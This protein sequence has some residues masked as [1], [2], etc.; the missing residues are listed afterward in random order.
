[1]EIIYYIPKIDCEK[2]IENN[3][4]TELKNKANNQTVFTD[5]TSL[6]YKF[7]L[8]RKLIVSIQ[9]SQ[10]VEISVRNDNAVEIKDLILYVNINDFNIVTDKR[11][12]VLNY[13]VDPKSGM[14]LIYINKILPGSEDK[15]I[16]SSGR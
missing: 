7:M 8:E 15:I 2:D 11:K 6:K 9:N 3:F 12:S 14:K 5:I 4:L 16:F 1:M 10:N 13:T